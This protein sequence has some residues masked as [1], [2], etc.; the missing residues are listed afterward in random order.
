MISSDADTISIE[1]RQQEGGSMAEGDPIDPGPDVG[2]F[3]D[4]DGVRLVSD[5]EGNVGGDPLGAPVPLLVEELLGAGLTAWFNGN[6]KDLFLG[7]KAP[8]I[9]IDSP[10]YP[11]FINCSFCYF[12]QCD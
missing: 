11:M 12:L 2:P 10:H 8:I 1:G 7:G 9:M 4:E 6:L 3:P 5:D